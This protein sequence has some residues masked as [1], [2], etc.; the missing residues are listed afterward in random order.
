MQEA[1]KGAWTIALAGYAWIAAIADRV[2]G[3]RSTKRNFGG[4]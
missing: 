3:A 1:G 4:V 2:R